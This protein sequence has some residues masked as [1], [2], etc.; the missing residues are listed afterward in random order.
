MLGTNVNEW[1]DNINNSATK[2]K[3]IYFFVESWNV[4]GYTGVSSHDHK[5]QFWKQRG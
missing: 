5:G 3:E 4:E 1:K 2:N